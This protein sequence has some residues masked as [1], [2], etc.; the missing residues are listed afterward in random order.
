MFACFSARYIS[1]PTGIFDV[2]IVPSSGNQF[3]VLQF[4]T[5]QKFVQG[6]VN[7]ILRLTSTFIQLREHLKNYEE[8]PIQDGHW[9]YRIAHEELREMLKHNP[10]AIS[11]I[12]VADR[13]TEPIMVRVLLLSN[14]ASL[15]R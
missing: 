10:S 14:L 2:K 1:S 8:N 5:N 12:L 11:S 3:Y 7:S 4:S 15:M 13:A 9:Q 6:V